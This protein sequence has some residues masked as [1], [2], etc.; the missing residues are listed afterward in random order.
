M[1]NKLPS[2]DDRIDIIGVKLPKKYFESYVPI[3][4]KIGTQ[5]MSASIKPSKLRSS[6]GGSSQTTVKVA[7]AC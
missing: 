2:K 3:D 7:A 1:I 4:P 5:Y 6:R